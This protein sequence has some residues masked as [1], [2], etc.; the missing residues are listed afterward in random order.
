ML[1]YNECLGL[2]TINKEYKE[3]GFQKLGLSLTREQE[4]HYC[5]TNHFDFNI[6]VLQHLK[7]Y[8]KSYI[9]K[10]GTGYWNS[11]I[12]DGT[13][14]IGVNNEGIVKGIPYQ[15]ELK[16]EW[17]EKV[18]LKTVTKKIKG[19]NIT[20]EHITVELLP[21]ESCEETAEAVHPDYLYYLEKKKQYTKQYSDFMTIYKQWVDRY[22]IVSYR[23][24]TIVNTEWSRA[25]LIDY[26]K[27]KDPTNPNIH[28]LQ[29]DFK[30]IY[31]SGEEI[32]D[33]KN[34]PNEPYYWVTHFKDDVMRQYKKDKPI[35]H[36]TFKQRNILYNL[37]IGVSEMIPYWLRDN[38]DVR[39]YVIRIHFHKCIA[40]PFYYYNKKWILC[41]RL[42]FKNQ[43]V[44][45]PDYEISTVSPDSIGEE[46]I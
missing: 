44:C 16:K 4:E 19:G 10:Y 5:N 25:L 3:F 17:V 13:I 35:F 26:I 33:L 18:V 7:Y 39:L 45:L 15:G 8:I 20:Q 42:Y 29:T 37:L 32:R 41:K 28:L 31:M 30:L 1:R 43:P 2:E 21:V 36:H 24:T 22:E 6:N 14:Y 34:D 27:Q 38:K 23:L 9:P 46:E 12:S 40:P 11:D